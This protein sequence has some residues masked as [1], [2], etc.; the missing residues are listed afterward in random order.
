MI[1][2]VQRDTPVL[3]DKAAE[4]PFDEI[5]SAKL[6]K[7]LADMKEALASQHDGIAIAAPQIGVSLRIFIVS[8]SLLKEADKTYSG[9]AEYLV[10]INPKIVRL[11]REKKDAEEGCLSVRWLYGRVP[12]SVKATLRAHNEKGEKIERGASGLLAQIF[13]HEVDHLD[14][15]LFTDKA[16]DLWEMDEEEIRELQKKG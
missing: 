6:K 14:G 4:V 16:S 9:P 5:G 11:S 3:R 1:D 12:R 13:Q 2:I 10:F 8:G 7:I 15:I